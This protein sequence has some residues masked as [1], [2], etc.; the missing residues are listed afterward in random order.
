MNKSMITGIVVGAIAVTAGGA[1]AG[2]KMLGQEYAEVTSVKPAM[3][4]IRTPREECND[5]DVTRQAP[6]KDEN[7]IAGTAI[8]AVVGGI[9]GHQIGGGD[10][11][12][13][14]TV[15]GAAGGGY[16]GNRIQKN[17][18]GKNTVT[19]TERECHTVYDKSEKQNGYEVTY[20]LDGR[21]QT[22]H[23]DRDPGRRIAVKDGQLVLPNG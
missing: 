13:I 14:A 17:M 16:A 2:Y 3:E 19:T 22:I 21:E 11:K 20:L 15:A 6:V 8:G 9:V 23:M 12:K 4:T 18:Q 7:R 1:I 5:V 10:G